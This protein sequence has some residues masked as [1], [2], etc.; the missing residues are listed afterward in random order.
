MARSSIWRLFNSSRVISPPVCR[1][2]ATST[3]TTNTIARVATSSSGRAA[4]NQRRIS[5]WISR[6]DARRIKGTRPGVQRA[7]AS[8]AVELNHWPVGPRCVR[9]FADRDVFVSTLESRAFHPHSDARFDISACVSTPWRWGCHRYLGS[10][11]IFTHEYPQ[12][13]T[14]DITSWQAYK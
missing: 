11:E 2:A 6:L 13:E 14:L 9:E 1:R 10:D 7:H 4:V 5:I 12:Q 3:L 8:T